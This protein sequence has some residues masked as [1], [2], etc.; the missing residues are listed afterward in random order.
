MSAVADLS[1]NYKREDLLESNA[2]F[3]IYGATAGFRAGVRVGR[4]YEFAQVTSGVVRASGTSF[5]VTDT[6]YAFA[7]QP[8]LGVD[9]P[10]SRTLAVR[11]QFDVRL[12]RSG[13]EGNEG[14]RQ[15]RF[16][17]GIVYRRLYLLI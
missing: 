9:Y 3:S 11:A 4:L 5:G 12:I 6:R 16:G 2:R 1:A 10:F 13:P 17:L 14:G 7:V 15:Y 8:G